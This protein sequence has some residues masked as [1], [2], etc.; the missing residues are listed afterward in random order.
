MIKSAVVRMNLVPFRTAVGLGIGFPPFPY[1]AYFQIVVQAGCNH[2]TATA[3]RTF[4][5]VVAAGALQF[6]GGPCII[7]INF[8][9]R[10]IIN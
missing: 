8:A 3:I 2:Q 10:I 5:F 6:V 7:T 9:H 1:S 4:T